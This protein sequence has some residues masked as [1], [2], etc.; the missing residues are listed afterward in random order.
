[1][2]ALALSIRHSDFVK[3]YIP[4]EVKALTALYRYRT[5]L[6]RSETGNFKDRTDNPPTLNRNLHPSMKMEHWLR[7]S[8]HDL[9]ITMKNKETSEQDSV[10]RLTAMVC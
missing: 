2:V 8:L 4:R 1:M 9:Q 6:P 10:S 7:K 3:L 5:A